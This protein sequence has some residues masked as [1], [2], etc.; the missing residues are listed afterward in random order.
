MRAAVRRRADIFSRGGRS[1]GERQ[2][3]VFAELLRRLRSQAGLTQEEL[4]EAARIGVR[5]G[6]DLESGDSA[7][8]RKET[9]RLLTDA[10]G[11]T[12]ARRAEIGAA[13]SGGTLP[14]R[15]A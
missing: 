7:T 3:P 9:A 11:L 4:A 5:T 6:S 2:A 1:V 8:A 15:L 10:P 13:D 12:G 14:G